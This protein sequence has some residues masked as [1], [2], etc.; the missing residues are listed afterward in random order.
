MV[1]GA[2]YRGGVNVAAGH[3]LGNP[4]PEL[5]VG[6]GIGSSSSSFA[7]AVNVYRGERLPRNAPFFVLGHDVRLQ[8]FTSTT[9]AVDLAVR[10]LNFDGAIDRLY[11]SN[12]TGSPQVKMYVVTNALNQFSVYAEQVGFGTGVGVG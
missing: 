2:G 5:F 12:T 4:K 1:F 8:A 3:Y 9:A 7:G 10:D 11:V 6:A